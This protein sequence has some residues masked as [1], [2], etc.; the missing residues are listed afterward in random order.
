MSYKIIR[1]SN[2][3][4]LDW[5]FGFENATYELAILNLKLALLTYTISAT[6]FCA[7]AALRLV[8]PGNEASSSFQQ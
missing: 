5:G 8:K 1:S 4:L 6:H 7:E 3:Y 2:P